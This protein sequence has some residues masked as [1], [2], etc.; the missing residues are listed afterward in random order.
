[1]TL[2]EVGRYRINRKLKLDL[3]TAHNDKRVL[4]T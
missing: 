4:T 1:M 2:A 3:N